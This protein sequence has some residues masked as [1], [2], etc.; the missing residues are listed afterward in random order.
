MP[1]PD[2]ESFML[3]L[4]RAVGDGDEHHV[5][6]V[7]DRL[8]A[9]F[10]LTAQE[11]AEMLPSGKQSV[12]DNRVGWAKTYL[13][14][15][16]LISSVRRGVYQITKEGRSVLTE[17]PREIT[18]SYLERFEPFR[19]FLT[20]RHNGDVDESSFSPSTD[21]TETPEEQLEVAYRRIRQKTEADV[22]AAV[23]T[24]SPQ[25]FEKLVIELLVKMGYGGTIA[26]AGEALGRTGDGGIDG[27]IK[28][29]KL[30]LDAIYVQAKRWQNTVGRPDIQGF[31]GSLLGR[32]GRKGVFITTSAFSKEAREY[33][34]QIEAKIILID[35]ATLAGLMVDHDVGVN[36]VETYAVKRV[37]SDYFSEE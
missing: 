27:V 33:V 32:R 36:T 26:D 37:D 25:F 23:K 20:L 8:A 1:V 17:R 11:R 10:N 15:A 13:D 29:D 22:L 24:A 16:G 2:Y 18:K 5:R 28:E 30:G 7:R 34:G 21:P 35:G 14:K 31:A 19:E 3:P 6:D 9:E 12:F 4:L